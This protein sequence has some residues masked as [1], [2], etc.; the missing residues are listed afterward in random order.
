MRLVGLLDVDP[1]NVVRDARAL[2]AC[3]VEPTAAV[4]RQHLEF[5]TL[6]Q[7]AADS[8]NVTIHARLRSI[9]C[10]VDDAGLRIDGNGLMDET[11]HALD[12]LRV[13]GAIVRDLED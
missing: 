4:D 3:C 7:L 10:L 12:R 5:S 2:S 13:R 8:R 9:L 6:R 1:V 11:S